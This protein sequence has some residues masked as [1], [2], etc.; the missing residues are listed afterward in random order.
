MQ[1]RMR[2]GDKFSIQLLDNNTMMFQG[3]YSFSESNNV[4]FLAVA[5]ILFLKTEREATASNRIMN[6]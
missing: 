1:K 2:N 6:Y 4:V 3:M 5:K